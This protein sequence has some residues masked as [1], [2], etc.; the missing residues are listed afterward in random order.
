MR[1]EACNAGLRHLLAAPPGRRA[2]R[3]AGRG[4]I[5]RKVHAKVLLRMTKWLQPDDGADILPDSRRQARGILRRRVRNAVLDDANHLDIEAFLD[6]VDRSARVDA[7]AI[8][9]NLFDLEPFGFQ[10]RNERLYVVSIDR[11]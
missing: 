5:L 11:V 7:G 2:S 3:S 4:G 9:R 10:P 8:R 1:A 6:L